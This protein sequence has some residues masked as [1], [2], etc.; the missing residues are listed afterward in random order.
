MTSVRGWVNSRATVRPE[1][2]CQWHHRESNLQ[3]SSL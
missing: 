1:G 2:L 3:T